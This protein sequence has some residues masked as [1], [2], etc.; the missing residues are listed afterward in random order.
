MRSHRGP[1]YTRRDWCELWP[2]DITDSVNSRAIACRPSYLLTARVSSSGVPPRTPG[3]GQQP[4]LTE[5]LGMARAAA[6]QHATARSVY[7]NLAPAT[8]DASLPLPRASPVLHCA[9]VSRR[10]SIPSMRGV[11]GLR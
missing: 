5:R 7:R 9:R 8:A 10:W 4:R 1:P 3:Q 2:T 11:H 6:G